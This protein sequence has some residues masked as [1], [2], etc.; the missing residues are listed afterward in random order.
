MT[1]DHIVDVGVEFKPYDFER[2]L[3]LD[4]KNRC[5]SHIEGLTYRENIIAIPNLAL[6]SYLLIF[7]ASSI[8]R[9][10]PYL[11]EDILSSETEEQ[12]DFCYEF[13]DSLRVVLSNLFIEFH[14][15]LEEIRSKRF[16]LSGVHP[17]RAKP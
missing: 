8:A 7:I 14:Q 9:Y 4:I 1:A 11:W 3:S 17:A 2:N 16:K 12:S 6:R 5:I 15:V 10:R 13:T